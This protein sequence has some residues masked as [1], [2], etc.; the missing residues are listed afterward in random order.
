M[1]W[2]VQLDLQIRF[3]HSHVWWE[4]GRDLTCR[5][6]LEWELGCP[7]LPY[8]WP[9]A[10]SRRPVRSTAARQFLLFCKGGGETQGKRML[11]IAQFAEDKQ[12]KDLKWKKNNISSVYISIHPYIGAWVKIIIYF[13]KLG[14]LC[15]VQGK[16][17]LLWKRRYFIYIYR[18]TIVWTQSGTR[19]WI[20]EAGPNRAEHQTRAARQPA[21]LWG[22]QG[23]QFI[24]AILEHNILSQ[25]LNVKLN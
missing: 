16:K 21:E 6:S 14:Y 20:A 19:M 3:P 9:W 15:Q 25:L 10:E 1:G 5:E 4:S 23:W 18:Q 12:H 22:S 11:T 8:P 13:S 2:K 24:S 7:A 17:K